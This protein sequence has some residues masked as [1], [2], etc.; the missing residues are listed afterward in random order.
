MRRFREWL[1]AWRVTRQQLR[2]PELRAVLLSPNFDPHDYVE[3]NR[4]SQ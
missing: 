3:A 2:D 1:H 4:P